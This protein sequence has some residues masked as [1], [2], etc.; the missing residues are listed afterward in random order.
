MTAAAV[1]PFTKNAKIDHTERKRSFRIV[2][3]RRY[4]IWV[5]SLRIHPL[6]GL[7]TI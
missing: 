5:K 2:M 6:T 7:E 4:K 1:P 3:N